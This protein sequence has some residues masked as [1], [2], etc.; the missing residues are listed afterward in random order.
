MPNLLGRAGAELH[1]RSG[2]FIN[3]VIDNTIYLVKTLD[4]AGKFSTVAARFCA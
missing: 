3:C 4:S 1:G 2:E